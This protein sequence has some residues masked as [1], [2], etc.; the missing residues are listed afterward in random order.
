MYADPINALFELVGAAFLMLNV[1]R[2]LIDRDLKGV[3]PWPTAFFSLWGI[4]NLYF[5]AAV[6]APLS[7]WAG[8]LLCTVNAIWL[9]GVFGLYV[10]KHA[11]EEKLKAAIVKAGEH[12]GGTVETVV[13]MPELQLTQELE[14]A[15]DAEAHDCRHDHVLDEPPLVIDLELNRKIEAKRLQWRQAKRR[16]RHKAK[17]KKLRLKIKKVEGRSFVVHPRRRK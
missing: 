5:Y 12:M 7:W 15:D 16:Q 10:E 8:L 3:S 13:A 4:W 11:Q 14:V 9:C 6:D 17:L 2:L 1:R